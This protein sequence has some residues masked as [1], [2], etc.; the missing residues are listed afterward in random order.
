MYSIPS[1]LKKRVKCKLCSTLHSTIS[2]TY[3]DCESSAKLAFPLPLRQA[4]NK[5]TT[6]FEYMF[7]IELKQSDEIEQI[8]TYKV[9]GT[10]YQTVHF[11][12]TFTSI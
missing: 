1:G 6:N 5:I 10:L 8:G 3:F 7:F 11:F 9:R 12:V 2:D 4:Q